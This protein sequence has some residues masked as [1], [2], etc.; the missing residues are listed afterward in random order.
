MFNKAFR[1]AYHETPTEFR[2]AHRTKRQEQKAVTRQ[3]EK[4]I[5]NLIQ[6]DG[7][8]AAPE[9]TGRLE[10]SAAAGDGEK[11]SFIW[12][13][14]INIGAAQDLLR[15][16][17]Q[18]HVILLKEGLHFTYARIWSPFTREMFIDPGSTA[19]TY[20]FSRLDAVFD[21]LVE[22]GLK[23]FL[24]IASKPRRVTGSVHRSL[25]L[26]TYESVQQDQNWERLL[27]AFLRH[28]VARYGREEVN[29]WKFELWFD[30]DHMGNPIL[31]AGYAN[32]LRTALE[33]VHR[34]SDAKVGGCGLHGYASGMELKA[35]REKAFQETMERQQVEPDFFTLYAYAY[36]SYEENG[37]V[38]S[39]QSADP[40]FMRVILDNARRDLAEQLKTKKLVVTEWNL[41]VS[42]RNP[43]NDSCYRAAYMVRNLIDMIGRTEAVACYVGSDRVLEFY[44]STKVLFG[45]NGLLSRDGIFKPAAYALE[46][47]NHLYPYCIAKNANGILT[48][49]R[50]G[51]FAAVL[52]NERPLNYTY[53]MT[54]EDEID[55]RH[56][57]RYF[58]DLNPLE[59]T[60]KIADLG[61][62]SYQ[63][64]MYRVGEGTGS[65]QHV[66]GKLGYEEDLSRE[67]VLY[68][69]RS[70]EPELTLQKVRTDGGT[71]SV[72][73]RLGA[74]EI[75]FVGLIAI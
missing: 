20:N 39:R 57:E 52:H 31:I 59:T 64:R 73:V 61:D 14:I 67:D 44:D 28:I 21:F 43:I 47:M 3:L 17:I 27:D 74:N 42:D 7:V 16:E 46:F 19:E 4:K 26:E 69:R 12:N 34:Y 10:L 41:S 5:Q 58:T 29:A 33:L 45:G 49:D 63:M 40:D 35:R 68:L 66:W 72:R 8:T 9:N 48:T 54:E 60:I 32:R 36:D 11:F 25:F 65:V 53:Y 50:H 55:Y 23:P 38:L 75:L 13:Q 24:E 6:G 37:K 62:R 2:S 70:C 71:L 51:N 30:S 1:E 15:S 56:L 22:H 18:K